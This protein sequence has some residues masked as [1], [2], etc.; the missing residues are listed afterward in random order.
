MSWPEWG[1]LGSRVCLWT[2]VHVLL[3]ISL[4]VPGGRAVDPHPHFSL[5][6]CLCW[7]QACGCLTPCMPK[8]LLKCVCFLCKCE[9]GRPPGPICACGHAGD[10]AS[11]GWAPLRVPG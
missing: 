11:M 10:Y 2:Y 1:W 9:S 7:P 8:S 4:S 3:G 6:D 5:C